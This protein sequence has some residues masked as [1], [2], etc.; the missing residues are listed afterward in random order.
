LQST[1]PILGSKLLANPHRP[2]FFSHNAGT[3]HETHIN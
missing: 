1:S 3:D 2:C